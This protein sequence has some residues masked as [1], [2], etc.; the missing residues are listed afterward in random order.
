M[1]I[2]EALLETSEIMDPDRYMFQPSILYIAIIKAIH[3]L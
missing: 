2:N 3:N 1:N